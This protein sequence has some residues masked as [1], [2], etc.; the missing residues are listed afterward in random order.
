LAIFKPTTTPEH[1]DSQADGHNDIATSAA[2]STQLEHGV[3]T[4]T[5]NPNTAIEQ[6]NDKESAVG[7]EQEQER[8]VEKRERARKQEAE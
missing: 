6:Q 3:A 7:R 5:T 4:T 2:S 1:L 8:R